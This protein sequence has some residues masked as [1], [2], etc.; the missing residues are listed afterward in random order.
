[1]PVCPAGFVALGGV[2]TYKKQYP[3]MG[4]CYCLA[5]EHVE[6]ASDTKT[7]YFYQHG[8]HMW[9]NP[10]KYSRHRDH[11]ESLKIVTA[12][13]NRSQRGLRTLSQGDQGILE[14]DDRSG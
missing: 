2:M 14:L 12:V 11:S 3:E 13:A 9:D 5:A 4:T 6:R 10:N 1:M 7:E 8:D